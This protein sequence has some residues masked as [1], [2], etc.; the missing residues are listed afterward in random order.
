MNHFRVGRRV[1]VLL[2]MLAAFLARTASAQV[3]TLQFGPGSLPPVPLVNHGDT[4]RYHLGTN[5]P[6]AGWQT[7]ADA[8]L[9]PI[10]WGSG[11]GGFGYEDGDDA[12]LVIMSNRCTT[13]Y[14]R[15]NFDITE[16]ADA[17]RH[18]QLVMDYDDGFIA[19][20]DGVEI[21]RSPNA[22]GGVG[23]EPSNT[24]TSLAPNHEAS[25]GS[26][27]NPPTVLDL[28]L[29]GSRLEPG[30]HTLAIL[31]LNGAINSSD[32]SLIPD[33]SLTGGS[34]TVVGGTFFTLVTASP[35]LL[36]GSNTFPGSARVTINGVDASFNPGAGTW[37]KAQAL[38]PGLNRLFI[39]AL[40]A[41]GAILTAT[42]RDVIFQDA[43]VAAGGTLSSSATWNS[44]N[45][46]VR[47]TNDV[48][49]PN[50]LSLTINPGVVVL[51]SAGVSIRATAGGTLPSTGPKR[52][53][54]SSSPQAAR[55]RG[56][57]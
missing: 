50:G 36:S 9:D 57:H 56:A 25:S 4:W 52:I 6:G 10:L 24:A 11:P 51:L 38:N 32:L 15:R 17:S 40:D 34:G 42:N 3:F 13:L 41:N 54:V 21:A 53:P 44:A 7:N 12:T 16:P 39:A 14:I 43:T 29:V 8:T 19:W 48:V 20:L 46:V 31:G 22:P 45:G 28:G 33:L 5:A 23:T 18:I 35:I 37:S 55:A 1:F 30:T 27:G 26:G 49:V 47:V 2:S